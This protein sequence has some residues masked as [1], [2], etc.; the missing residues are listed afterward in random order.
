MRR[1]FAFIAMLLAAFAVQA[2]TAWPD[3][4][5]AL[6]PD[7]SDSPVAAVLPAD[8][9]ITAPTADTRPELQR[10][11]GLWQGWA[12]AGRACDVKVAVERFEAD[13][14]VVAYAGASASGT[15]VHRGKAQ[16]VADELHLRL[17]TEAN[18]V[19]RLRTGGDM[20]ISLWRPDT[21][22]RFA[23]VLTRR[24]LEVPWRR[25]IERL[26]TPWTHEGRPV[27]LVLATFRPLQGDGPWPTLVVNH[28]STG[29]GD[30]PDFFGHLSTHRELVRR[31]TARGWQVIFPQRRGRGGS[32]GLYD[33]GFEADRSR[34]SCDPA[35]SLPGFER[36]LE[37]LHHVMQHIVARPDVD[38]R[39]VMLS[40]VSRGGILSAAYAGLHPAHVRGVINFVGGWMGDRCVNVE[41][42]NPVLFRRGAAYPLPMLWLYGNRDSFYSLR[43]SRANFEAFRAA[44]GQGRF[45]AYELPS[46]EN[47]HFIADRPDLW[48]R[49]V[50][51]YLEELPRP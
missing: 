13:G 48:L 23:G 5:H 29:N 7:V 10:W 20:E 35:R 51:S 38:A 3:Y 49:D 40:G 1:R 12:C 17:P 22:L 34:Y 14:V 21:Q 30:R 47:G 25:A 6:T 44:G 18:L 46:G 28:G 16:F 33:E 31:F 15:N 9:A 27:S 4:I 32:G 2:R 50:E 19:M 11:S 42:I 43:H 41:R 8:V 24:S 39:R 26:A 45:V 37:D 36:A